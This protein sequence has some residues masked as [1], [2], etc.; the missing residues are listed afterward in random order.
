[1]FV[2]LHTL[3]A[4]QSMYTLYLTADPQ[5]TARSEMNGEEEDLVLP[6][7][8]NGKAVLERPEVKAALE[9]FEPGTRVIGIVDQSDAYVVWDA[10]AAGVE[11]GA[12]DMR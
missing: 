9:G 3:P 1:M 2:N 10:F 12:N 7:G 8:L 6:R 4:G 5:G 11:T